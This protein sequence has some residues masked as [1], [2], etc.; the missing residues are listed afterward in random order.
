[1]S[2][3]VLAGGSGFLGRAL[4]DALKRREHQTVV[5]SRSDSTIPNADEVVVWDGKSMGGWMD[6]LYRADCIV[7]LCGSP[8]ER[9][10]S[11]EQKRRIVASRVE[12]TRALGQALSKLSS[13]PAQ[14]V[15]ISAIGYYGNL[16]NRLVTEEDPPGEDFLGHACSSWEAAQ[17]E[18]VPQDVRACRIRLGVV[19][20]KQD[21]F[22][23]II[24][25][26]A[27]W[28][29]GGAAGSGKQ[30][31]SWIHL[32]DAVE[33]MLWALEKRLDGTWNAVA[34]HPLTNAEL[35][36]KVRRS[37]GRPWCPPAPAFL[38]KS[39]A[40]LLGK[41]GSVILG[42]QRVSAE[43]CVSA[44]FTFQFPDVD[45]ALDNLLRGPR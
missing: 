38:I 17:L 1:M 31:V 36:A 33:L 9:R 22:L 43:K 18:T 35:M 16:V 10:W 8:I 4:L 26:L 37:L 7:N 23:P 40:T 13:R 29:L 34:P 28:F 39:V 42:G 12:P 3:V 45:S 32:E 11:G 14:W 2:R 6:A 21:G 5:L 25:S 27:R 44:G 24:A 20:G 19:M 41:E 30:W 15:N